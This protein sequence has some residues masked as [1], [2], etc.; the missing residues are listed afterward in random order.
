MSS[1]IIKIGLLLLIS[2]SLFSG[3]ALAD[4]QSLSS[5][6]K[7]D[8][9]II[10]KVLEVISP[11]FGEVQ[12]FT[13][14]DVAF[15]EEEERYFSGLSESEIV[16]YTTTYIQVAT[17]SC[18]LPFVSNRVY[19]INPTSNTYKVKVEITGTARDGSFTTTRTV[20]VA[21]RNKVVL[22]CTREGAYPNTVNY[23]F[24]IASENRQW[25]YH[26]SSPDL[27]KVSERLVFYDSY[28][29]LGSVVA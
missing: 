28:F 23:S 8:K 15:L 12:V 18:G 6:M 22:G 21:S 20:L 2:F 25:N 16:A 24:V 29:R 10:E 9:S 11:E 19:L 17:E 26:F 27:A 13:D 1:W 5:D 14:E 3:T 7:T 4:T